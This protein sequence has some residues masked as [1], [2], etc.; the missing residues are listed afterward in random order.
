M[1]TMVIWSNLAFVTDDYDD[2]DNYEHEHS[3]ESSSNSSFCM[4]NIVQE[5]QQEEDIRKKMEELEKEIEKQT[6]KELMEGILVLVKKLSNL[7]A[8]QIITSLKKLNLEEFLNVLYGYYNKCDSPEY[9]T[10]SNFHSSQSPD[11]SEFKFSDN[12]EFFVEQEEQQAFEDTDTESSIERSWT[13][14]SD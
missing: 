6:E 4:R 8:K 12:H 5:Q 14:H 10:N 13:Y 1:E 9:W 3:S 7:K 2:E 11:Q